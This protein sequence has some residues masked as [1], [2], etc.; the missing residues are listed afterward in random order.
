ME[1]RSLESHGNPL[2][3]T[4]VLRQEKKVGNA[5][6]YWVKERN[7]RQ[8]PPVFRIGKGG[9]GGGLRGRNRRQGLSLQSR[10]MT[11][12]ASSGFDQRDHRKK[13]PARKGGKS[14]KGRQGGGDGR[15]F[16]GEKRERP[17]T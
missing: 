16:T 13:G 1:A 3:L 8:H 2:P 5:D 6:F 14:R 10:E 7:M 12:R 4:Y 11:E 15:G 17:L 9:K